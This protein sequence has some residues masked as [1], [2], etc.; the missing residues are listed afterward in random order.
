MNAKPVH[1][2]TYNGRNIIVQ[3]QG[4]LKGYYI[5]T[6]ETHKGAFIWGWQLVSDIQTG[7]KQAQDFIDKMDDFKHLDDNVN[8]CINDDDHQF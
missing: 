3:E 4:S 6:I 2:E 1:A 5:V 7:I 8:Y